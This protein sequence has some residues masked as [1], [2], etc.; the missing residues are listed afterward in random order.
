MQQGT[1]INESGSV[2]RGEK[3]TGQEGKELCVIRK[4]CRG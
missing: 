2:A 4:A 3:L 1:L